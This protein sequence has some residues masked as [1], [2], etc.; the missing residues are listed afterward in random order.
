MLQLSCDGLLK[1][2]VYFAV[3]MELLSA[4]E[5]L[6][7]VTCAGALIIW[8]SIGA[9]SRSERSEEFA[10]RLMVLFCF[11]A[12]GSLFALHY[13]DGAIFGS[14]N[15]ARVMAVVCIAIG[16]SATLNIK[17]KEVQGEPNPHAVRRARL[18]EEE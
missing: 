7:T 4:L 15:L 3:L 18:A 17:G 13:A 1:C 8:M 5:T 2:R 6:S 11:V 14:R 16:L 9:L 12:A 10:Q